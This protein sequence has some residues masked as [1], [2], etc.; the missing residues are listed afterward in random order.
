MKAGE[1]KATD[2]FLHGLVSFFVDDRIAQQAGTLLREIRARGMT[3]G[4]ADAIIAT[5][6]LQFGIPLLTN[7]VEHYPFP[8]L[9]LIKGLDV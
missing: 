4:I 3:S 1:E 7:N 5:T 9:K 8:G 2:A 6:A